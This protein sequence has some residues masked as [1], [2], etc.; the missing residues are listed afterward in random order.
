[1]WGEIF[2]LRGMNEWMSLSS[3]LFSHTLS[4]IHLKDW[5]F[6]QLFLSLGNIS[7]TSSHFSVV[8]GDSRGGHCLV[9]LLYF[10]SVPCC[11]SKFLLNSYL[12]LASSLNLAVK[13]FP[14]KEL[15]QYP[16]DIFRPQ[17]LLQKKWATCRKFSWAM[18]HDNSD[19][20]CHSISICFILIVK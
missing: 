8:G 11:I 17:F 19:C 16:V 4:F 13:C 1:M 9:P 5:P 12:R 18:M 10:L 2:P 15:L 3:F 20:Q 7:W 14:S 6:F